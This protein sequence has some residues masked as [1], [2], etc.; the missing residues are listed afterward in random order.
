MVIVTIPLQ[1]LICVGGLSIYIYRLLTISLW[2]YNGVLEG[3]G[4]ILLVVF[5]CKL[6]GQ[7]NTVNV[8]KEVLFLIFLLDAKCIIHIPEP[9][10]R[11]WVAVL[12]AFAQSTPYKG[13]Q[14]WVLLGTP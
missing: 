5:H 7:V 9:Y 12:R 4:P 8:F 2:F 6:Y 10:S 1:I 3:D 13:W 14:L 11:G